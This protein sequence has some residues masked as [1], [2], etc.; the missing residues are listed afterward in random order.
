MAILYSKGSMKEAKMKPIAEL[1]PEE[2]KAELEYL[3]TD[4]SRFAVQ[5]CR[6]RR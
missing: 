1:T 5:T 3:D 2:A 6:R 4:S